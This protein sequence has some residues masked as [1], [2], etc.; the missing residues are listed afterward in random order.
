LENTVKFFDLLSNE[1]SKWIEEEEGIRK[2]REKSADEE[3][4][5]N[6]DFGDNEEGNASNGNDGWVYKERF[7]NPFKATS[8]QVRRILCG[9]ENGQTDDLGNT[10][11]YN[12]GFIYS[13]LISFLSK[14]LE[15]A[16]DFMTL[17]RPQDYTED[18]KDSEGNTVT[19]ASYPKG[20]PTFPAI[21]KM[22]IRYPWADQVIARL[23]NDWRAKDEDDATQLKYPPT[24]GAVASQFY[25]NFFKAF[26]PSAKIQVGVNPETG[27]PYFG[28][29]PLNY[30]MEERSQRDALETAYNNGMTY[31]DDSLYNHDKTLNNENAKKIGK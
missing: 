18:M 26:I 31:S 14:N 28:T 4:Q 17:V 20:Y 23:I 5:D 7:N 30:D 12:Q 10:K 27:K 21:E 22:R 19:A 3:E 24:Y 6:E 13:A 8:K 9:I 11:T 15:N 1:A 16:D 2:G 25:T 29:T